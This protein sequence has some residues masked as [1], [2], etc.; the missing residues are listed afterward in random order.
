MDTS[1]TDPG[2]PSRR[3][4]SLDAVKAP[5]TPPGESTSS[6]GMPV[7]ESAAFGEFLR[8]ARERRRLTL[9]QIADNT[10]ISPRHLTALERGN[11]GALPQGMYRRAMLR[12]YAESVGLDKETALEQFEK[13][14]EHPRPEP[15]AEPASLPPPVA[16][17]SH[18]PAVSLIAVAI[19]ATAVVALITD[20]SPMQREEGVA[21]VQAESVD[22]D[23]APSRKSEVQTAD[24]R[25]VA[26]PA[27]TIQPRPDAM[28]ASAGPVE[29]PV[30]S[31]PSAPR[32]I[33]TPVAVPPPPVVDQRRVQA[34]QSVD[35]NNA[36]SPTSG[37]ERGEEPRTVPVRAAA[38]AGQLVVDSQ[39]RGARVSVN[40]IGWG[41]TP[42]SIPYVPFGDK[43]I[44][45]TLDGYPAQER[46]VSVTPERPRATVRISF[47]EAD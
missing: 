30:A 34:L 1:S 42:V 4:H 10:K 29:R 28:T 45:L 5:T 35:A 32:A 47:S 40:G 43:R 11:V 21:T 24:L 13:T 22:N 12:A 38:T 41:V 46:S 16:F 37:N 44:R 26:L 17:S 19:V 6:D 23:R 20:D 25:P 9:A 39:P 2:S 7:N 33:V 27:T 14:F 36:V 3:P 18:R 8:Q 15:A 31:L